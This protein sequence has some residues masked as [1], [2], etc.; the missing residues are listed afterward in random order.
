MLVKHPFYF[1]YL[2]CCEVLCFR[3]YFALNTKRKK[4]WEDQVKMPL[5]CTAKSAATLGITGIANIIIS[6]VHLG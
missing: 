5:T 1:T 3:N 4:D 2:L 6:N